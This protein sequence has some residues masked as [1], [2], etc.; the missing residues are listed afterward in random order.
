M[1]K[2]EAETQEE[3][4]C[5]DGLM[6]TQGCY[7]E[8]S[9]ENYEYLQR[10]E[11]G[12][13]PADILF[14]LD[15]TESMSLEI[16][17]FSAAFADMAQAMQEECLIYSNM[18]CLSI[19]FLVLGAESASDPENFDKISKPGFET[20]GESMGLAQLT[21]NAGKI[22]S[23]KNSIESIECANEKEPWFDAL[24]FALDQ[25]NN[26]AVGWRQGSQ[27]MVFL[28]TGEPDASSSNSIV[29]AINSV[30]S[31]HTILYGAAYN[32]S[33]E[34]ENPFNQAREIGGANGKI[35]A[36]SLRKDAGG[37]IV[38]FLEGEN[39]PFSDLLKIVIKEIA[40]KQI[41]DSGKVK[42]DEAQCGA[43]KQ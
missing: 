16:N 12:R 34:R 14:V 20:L 31:N 24:V 39:R 40:E 25:S 27:K 10:L 5:V 15:A 41:L 19:G 7:C 18:N 32:L 8:T 36:Y 1:V 2:L 9:N 11:T 13:A 30:N 29:T 42:C 21:S 35:Y 3:L 37:K 17:E 4:E 26:A 23:F 28:L 43:C 33:T 22:L 38:L 6:K